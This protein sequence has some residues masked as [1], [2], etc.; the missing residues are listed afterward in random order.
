M[1][2]NSY[3]KKP[4]PKEMASILAKVRNGELTTKEVSRIYKVRVSTAAEWL[5]GTERIKWRHQKDPAGFDAAVMSLLEGGEYTKIAVAWQCKREKL[6]ARFLELT[7]YEYVW[8]R[9]PRI[10]VTQP[11]KG[12]RRLYIV[13]A[14]EFE[15]DCLRVPKSIS[16]TDMRKKWR[17]GRKL[18]LDRIFALTGKVIPDGRL[19]C[20]EGS[21]AKRE[22]ERQKREAK[23]RES[24]SERRAA[25]EKSKRE[26]LKAE[27]AALMQAAL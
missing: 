9:K 7:G 2:R 18:I 26:R 6:K 17:C 13:K 23:A 8:V 5:Q 10:I 14:A 20:Y 15:A 25:A 21:Q 4:F 12:T 3:S 19:K 27:V 24:V 1:S 22:I 11:L 16:V